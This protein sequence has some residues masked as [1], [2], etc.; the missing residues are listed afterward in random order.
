[1][2][3]KLKDLIAQGK[4]IPFVGAGVSM[5]IKDKEGNSL[6]PSWTGL[7]ESFIPMIKKKSTQNVIKAL[8]EDKPVDY[9]HI[10]DRIKENL[11]PNDFNRHLKEYLKIDY[12][13]IDKDS[14]ALPKSIWELGS[15]LIITT[16]Y[17]N[18]MHKASEDENIEYWDIENLHEQG[19][20]FRDG[21]DVSTVW[22]LH[23]NINNIN[24]IILTTEKYNQLYSDNI[25]DSQYKSALHTL[26]NI[27]TNNSLLFIGFSLNDEFFVNQLNRIIQIFGGNTHEHYV[28]LKKGHSVDT[29]EGNIKIIDYTD[30]GQPLIELI[31]SLKPNIPKIYLDKIKEL[32]AKLGGDVDEFLSAYFGQDYQELLIDE[33]TYKN[34]KLKLQNPN[35]SLSELIKEKDELE[36]KIEA[37]TLNKDTQTKIDEALKSLR[38]EEVRE[39][40]DNY[41]K[42]TEHILED[43]IK[44]H[45]QKA[46][47]YKEQG[48]YLNAK[49]EIENINIKK[50]EDDIIL[51]DYGEIYYFCG[52]YSEAFPLF[53]KALKIREESLGENH[54]DTAISYGNLALLYHAMGEYKK[55]EPLFLKS[56]KIKEE[57]LGENHPSTA[58]SYNNLA[59]LYDAMGEYQKSYGFMKRA[60]EIREFVLPENHPYTIGSRDNLKEIEKMLN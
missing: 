59:L 43:R 13:S 30:H 4:V 2:K 40:L 24:N 6:F 46:L 33:N 25:N 36:K 48:Q 16:N 3:D 54:P 20:A 23:G 12:N 39:I 11:T 56:Q 41:L 10:A 57:V 21:L 38:F 18:I 45:Y 49:D 27:I 29:L 8:L 26:Q 5:D 31:Q 51:N 34:F 47:T 9:L 50:L 15:K 42:E 32:I 19:N 55:A 37:Y 17:D 52:E 28:L 14:Y 53:E 58:T 35:S 22:N 44:A 1:M 60:L 7:L